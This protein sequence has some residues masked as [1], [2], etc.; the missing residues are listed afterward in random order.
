MTRIILESEN[1]KDL[2]LITEL[3][4]RLKIKYRIESST[5]DIEKE[6]LDEVL[7][8]GTDISNYGDPVSWQRK[9]RKDRRVI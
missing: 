3:A 6:K 4:E 2:F 8:K 5:S 1:K 7:S 9:V